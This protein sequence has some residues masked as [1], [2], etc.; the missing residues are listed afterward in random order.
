MTS[1]Q[2]IGSE[3]GSD[4]A[5]MQT[6]NPS[7]FRVLMLEPMMGFEPA[8]YCLRNSCSTPELHRQPALF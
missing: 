2:I 1:H 3:V 5:Q 8:T 7:G 6:R 4:R